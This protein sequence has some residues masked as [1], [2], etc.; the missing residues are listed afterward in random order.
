MALPEKQIIDSIMGK[1]NAYF[2]SKAFSYFKN[3]G[4]SV[5]N[6]V[7]QKYKA[8][9][10]VT[11]SGF[12]LAM[13]T[14]LYDAMLESFAS[15]YGEA[16]PLFIV[17][18][19]RIGSEDIALKQQRFLNR[20]WERM[21]QSNGGGTQQ[22]LAIT[23]DVP[24]YSMGVA[25]TKW[26]REGSWVEA[27]VVD[28]TAF[29]SMITWKTEFQY[30]LDEPEVERTHPF[31]WFGDWTSCNP[32]WEGILRTWRLSDVHS[33]AQ[34]EQFDKKALKELMD[35]LKKG[36]QGEDKDF[37]R[38]SGDSRDQVMRGKEASIIE[39]WGPLSDV[40]GMEDDSNEY[41]VICDEKRI[42]KILVNK[43]PGFR[44]IRRTYSSP[45]NDSPFGR[46]LL[47]PSL[48]H[49]KILNLATNLGID[50]TITRMHHG[51][52][53]WEDYL[54]NPNDL[55]NP[56][57]TNGYVYMTPNATPNHIPR[58][59]GGERSGVL[60]DLMNITNLVKVD[61]E[62]VSDTDQNLGIR[63]EKSETATGR[64]LLKN[65]DNKRTRAAII[66]MAQTGLI[67][68]GKMV[69]LMALK[70]T[71]EVERMNMSYDGETFGI[72][73]DELLQIW[74]NNVFDVSDSILRDQ[75]TQALKLTNFLAGARDVL[76]QDPHG[77][78][79]ILNIL[80]DVGRKT[81][82]QNVER[83]LPENPP[84]QA[85]PA[86]APPANPEITPPP[87]AGGAPIGP[88]GLPDAGSPIEEQ[89]L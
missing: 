36:A 41:Q 10:Q 83:Y 15:I 38:E 69:N 30:M 49:T 86:Q 32:Q 17:D 68:I 4:E 78:P 59:I 79:K 21:G 63:G 7:E 61:K 80:R 5:V 29:N 76:L 87:Q 12:Y 37:Y 51:W 52:A 47:A 33:A 81:G 6:A 73:N 31:N 8:R 53:V 14:G 45:R 50:D 56:E 39:Y 77:L 16:N 26:R 13:H 64:L 34:D 28:Q 54:E 22:W 2:G 67:P 43:I 42:Y 58:R 40:K 88:E 46:S 65:A 11:K 75:E 3:Q 35:G 89:P 71:P 18:S 44:P 82:I 9:E 27:P 74:N 57:G 85:G 19:K 72:S 48:P 60:D 1:K 23:K 55:A 24:L 66:T 70:N 62:R 20:T 84:I 25:Y